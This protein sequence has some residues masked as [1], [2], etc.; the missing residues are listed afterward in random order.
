[1][2]SRFSWLLSPTV[3]SEEKTRE[4]KRESG[5]VEKFCG[6]DKSVVMLLFT[7]LSTGSAGGVR[8]SGFGGEGIRVLPYY[9]L[10]YFAAGIRLSGLPTLSLCPHRRSSSDP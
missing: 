2:A 8:G 10:C 5:S 3:Q 6:S 1:M 4:K 7:V 9:R